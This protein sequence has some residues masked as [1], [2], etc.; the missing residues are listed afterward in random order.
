VIV[1]IRNLDLT[2]VQRLCSRKENSQNF[3][4]DIN[5]EVQQLGQ[6]K[7]YKCTGVRESVGTQN[8]QMKERVKK[9]STKRLRMIL[10]SKLKAKNKIIAI[11]ALVM[12]VLRYSFCIIN[13]RLEE[14]REIDRETTKT[15]TMYKIHHPNVDIRGK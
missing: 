11:G 3:I 6:G 14:I 8:K 9:E 12:P 15:L 1:S 2:R 10:K 4:L 5:K 13:W 7:P